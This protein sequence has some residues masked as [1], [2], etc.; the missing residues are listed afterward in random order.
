MSKDKIS[1]NSQ[2]LFYDVDEESAKWDQKIFDLGMASDYKGFKKH[3]CTANELYMDEYQLMGAID[4]YFADDIPEEDKNRYIEGLKLS[5]AFKKVKVGKDEIRVTMKADKKEIWAKRVT[6]RIPETK[7]FMPEIATKEGREGQ[8][9]FLSMRLARALPFYADVVT[10]YIYGMSDK[11]KYLH[12]WVEYKNNK[13]VERVIDCTMNALMPKES[14]YYLR[15][16]KAVQRISN[17]N[18]R[19]DFRTIKSAGGGGTLENFG[20]EIK[21]YLFFRDE[22]VKDFSK[23]RHMFSDQSMFENSECEE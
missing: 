17:E 2:R 8:C 23:N 14:Y 15:Q 18:L 16:A 3:L 11:A 7:E 9:H 13:G 10:G 19:R 22:I 6:G 12:T 1:V 21:T 20:L 4:S 5:K